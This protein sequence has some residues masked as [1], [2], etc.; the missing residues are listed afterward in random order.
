MLSS[1]SATNKGLGYKWLALANTL[2]YNCAE[3]IKAIKDRVLKAQGCL[4]G[5]KAKLR[6]LRRPILKGSFVL[7]RVDNCINK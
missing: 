5:E 7:G 4:N 2:D 3:L 6:I 1:A